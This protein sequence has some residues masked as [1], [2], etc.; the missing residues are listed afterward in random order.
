MG[1]TDIVARFGGEEFCIL[2]ADMEASE[3]AKLFED[4]RHSIEVTPVLFNN[5]ESS[6]QVAV[7]IGVCT[8]KAE[9]LEQMTKFAD[10]LLYDAKESGRNCVR[11]SH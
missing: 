4:M 1:D 5:K 7:S 8:E 11:M 3:A 10:D 6:L 2:A 9:N